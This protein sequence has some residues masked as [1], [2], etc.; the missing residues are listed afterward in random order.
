MPKLHYYF[1]VQFRGVP[2]LTMVGL[3]ALAS[4]C[5]G[6]AGVFR[7]QV[8]GA[9]DP[10]MADF[11]NVPVDLS[12]T[13]S[14]KLKNTSEAPFTIDSI[15]VP[16][17]FAIRAADEGLLE[18]KTIPG[19]VE[20][21]LEVVFLSID[22]STRTDTIVVHA[23]ELDIPLQLQATGVLQRIP[24]FV[25]EPPVINFG[26]A[27]VG[28]D[29]RLTFSLT[30]EGNAPGTIMNASYAN[31]SGAYAVNLPGPIIVQETVR[32]VFMVTFTPPAEGA[33]PD[34]LLLEVA[35]LPSPVEIELV[36][37]GVGQRGGFLCNPPSVS[38]GQ[39]ER[40]QTRAR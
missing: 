20:I 16:L 11:G 22:E 1:G 26:S 9:F 14:V 17:A 8:S 34:R 33:Y 2:Q 18:G 6:D 29:V 10:P 7:L 24:V 19:G 3:L 28:Q 4:G 35:E 21:E 32:G 40:G 37:E 25:L 39:V 38:F 5:E 13:V 36:G 12:K 31:N 15:D 30:N 23:G 27:Q